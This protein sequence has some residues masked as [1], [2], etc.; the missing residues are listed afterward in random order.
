[1]GNMNGSRTGVR[2][3]V[4]L[5]FGIALGLGLPACAGQVPLVAEQRVVHADRLPPE[6]MRQVVRYSVTRRGHTILEEK[7]ESLLIGLRNA[8]ARVTFDSLWYRIEHVEGGGYRVDEAGK[9]TVGARYVRV[10]RAL[11]RYIDRELRELNR[12]VPVPKRRVPFAGQ[13]ELATVKAAV[14]RALRDEDCSIVDYDEGR[15]VAEL[16]G[17]GSRSARIVVDYDRDGFGVSPAST[18]D[19]YEHG[20]YISPDYVAHQRDLEQRVARQ[21]QAIEAERH[22]RTMELARAQSGAF[23]PKHGVL[24][25]TTT[26]VRSC[27]EAV[28]RH[29]HSEMDAD[30]HCDPAIRAGCAD[31]VLAYGHSLT[32]LM[33]CKGVTD[34]PCVHETLRERS[35]TSLSWCD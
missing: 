16:P 7:P 27:E 9:E 10:V 24:G 35:P 3:A 33:F 5:A 20:G 32:Q 17:R 8:K 23:V 2:I 12:L 26:A 14:V 21:L 4:G 1:M 6:L 22:E 15:V 13:P 18:T 29:G 34:M 31:A 30:F 19:F 11:A 28:V 25:S